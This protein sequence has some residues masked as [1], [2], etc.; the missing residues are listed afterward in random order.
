MNRKAAPE[1]SVGAGETAKP[2]TTP[3][4]AVIPVTRHWVPLITTSLFTMNVSR[5]SPVRLVHAPPATEHVPFMPGTSGWV[6][7]TTWPTSVSRARTVVFHD[8]FRALRHSAGFDAADLLARAHG[9]QAQGLGER[10]A[11]HEVLAGGERRAGATVV[12][13]VALV[14]VLGGVGLI[15]VRLVA[16]S[17]TRCSKAPS[18]GSRR[19]L[20]SRKLPIVNAAAAEA[21]M[22]QPSFSLPNS[23]VK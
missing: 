22:R 14:L 9:R 11:A 1:A 23:Q 19:R 2:V 17:I 20:C 21:L 13:R 3:S 4:G 15:L 10:A 18:M 6:I 7:E 12:S 8:A 16:K 5:G